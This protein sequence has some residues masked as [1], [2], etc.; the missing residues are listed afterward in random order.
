M[1]ASRCARQLGQ[2]LLARAQRRHA[3]R[4]D[5]QAVVEVLAEAPGLHLGQQVAVGGGDQAHVGVARAPLAHPLVGPLLQH[6]QQLAL[7]LQRQ[8]AHLVEEQRAAA[9]RL[10][11]PDAVAHRAREGA[12]HVSEQ[13]ALAT[14][15]AGWRRSSPR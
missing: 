9:G 3:D 7:Q 15:R 2:V 10:E 1:R 11:A 6:A 14:A 13:L 4:V 8:L 12:A 5:R